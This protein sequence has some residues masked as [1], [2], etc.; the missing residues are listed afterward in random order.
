MRVLQATLQQL[1]GTFTLPVAAPADALPASGRRSAAASR[2]RV[3]PKL[4]GALPGM[5]RFFETYPFTCLE[6]KTSKAVGLRDAA[7]WAAVANTLPTYLDSD[8][9]ANYFPPRA[10]DGAARQRPPHRLRARAPRT[11][12]ASRCPPPRA[13][14]MLDG[15]TAFVEG[16]IERK[17]WSPRADLDVRKLAAI[18]ALSRHGRAQAADARLGQPHAQPV[19]HRGGDRLAAASCSAS[20]GIPDQAQAAGR[21]AADP[22]Q[23]PDLR[24]HHAAASAPRTTTSGGG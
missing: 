9:L 6:Q 24:R 1:D 11:R 22:A 5:R 10:E 14:P 15:L 23:P 20:N 18:E 2:S 17:F 4:S 16:R 3:Q 7:L 21:S 13:T 19:A 8:G 12:P